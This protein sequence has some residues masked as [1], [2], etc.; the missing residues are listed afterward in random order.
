MRLFSSDLS[1]PHAVKLMNQ[2]L[3]RKKDG[4]E[5]SK[6]LHLRESYALKRRS[7]PAGAAS[8][9]SEQGNVNCAY[10]RWSLIWSDDR[11]SDNAVVVQV[12]YFECNSEKVEKKKEKN[13]GLNSQKMAA[14]F[15]SSDRKLTV[16]RE[17]ISVYDTWRHTHVVGVNVCV[18]QVISRINV[19]GENELYILLSYSIPALCL[20][21][22]VCVCVCVWVR[23]FTA[24]LAVKRAS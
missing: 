6:L 7:D 13:I 17:Q 5:R 20:C 21:V 14:F 11:S 3:L 24:S 4:D 18:L 16:E 15:S 23:E 2:W 1:W 12:S 19:F 9:T 10:P 22:C 8:L